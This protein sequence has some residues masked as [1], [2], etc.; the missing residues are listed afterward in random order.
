MKF[1]VIAA[2]IETAIVVLAF[3]P[4]PYRLDRDLPD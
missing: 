4:V 2:L 1:L 3:W